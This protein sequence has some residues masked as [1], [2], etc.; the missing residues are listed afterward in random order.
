[1]LSPGTSTLGMILW[2]LTGD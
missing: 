1:M 2:H